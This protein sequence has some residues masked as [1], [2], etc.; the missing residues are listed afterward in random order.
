MLS[1]ATVSLASNLSLA[2]PLST[3]VLKNRIEQSQ[4]DVKVLVAEDIIIVKRMAYLVSHTAVSRVVTE[5]SVSALR[6][7]KAFAPIRQATEAI[8]RR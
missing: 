1:L 4:R 2:G 6:P 8:K 5:S 7:A 3:S